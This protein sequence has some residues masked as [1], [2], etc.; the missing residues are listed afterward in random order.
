MQVG[1]PAGT[2][3]NHPPDTWARPE[4][5]ERFNQDQLQSIG[6][7][8]EFITSGDWR[9]KHSRGTSERACLRRRHATAR[10]TLDL[11]L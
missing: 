9:G 2:T 8:E 7:E 6:G 3:S 1:G 4:V 10:W 5:T 11:P